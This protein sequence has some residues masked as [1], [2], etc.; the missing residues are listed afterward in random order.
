MPH[1]HITYNC[2]VR[3]HSHQI[4]R[5]D[6]VED[7]IE[8]AIKA[9]K[10]IEDDTGDEPDAV[11]PTFWASPCDQDGNITDETDE[12]IEDEYDHPGGYVYRGDLLSFVKMLADATPESGGLVNDNTGALMTPE[13]IRRTA[14]HILKID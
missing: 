1:Y 5:A 4:V 14:R 2:N 6:N 3:S 10:W 7:A 8:E 13:A 12:T 11:E 9:D